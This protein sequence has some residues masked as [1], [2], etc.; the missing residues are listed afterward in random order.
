MPATRTEAA[1]AIG[2]DTHAPQAPK[3]GDSVNNNG[4]KKISWRVVER[5]IA[6]GARPIYWKKPPAT[7]WKPTRG[8]TIIAIPKP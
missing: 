2:I 7:T 5:N 1:S 3:R 8:K 4:N 6:R